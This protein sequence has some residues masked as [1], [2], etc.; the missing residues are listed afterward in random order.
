MSTHTSHA[1]GLGRLLTAAGAVADRAGDPAVAQRS[2]G[3][4]VGSELL[5]VALLDLQRMLRGL[6]AVSSA[7]SDAPCGYRP[8]GRS[9]WVSAAEHEALVR[10][11]AAALVRTEVVAAEVAAAVDAVSSAAV[12]LDD[13]ALR[14]EG[15]VVCTGDY[16][17]A[18]A[19]LLDV[20]TA[21]LGPLVSA[22]R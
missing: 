6:V 2:G 7:V 21:A 18:W 9:P 5:V 22:G 10:A 3:G 19:D 8:D 14:P 20:R 17:G 16:L 15:A 4:L 11:T 1:V 12:A 13:G